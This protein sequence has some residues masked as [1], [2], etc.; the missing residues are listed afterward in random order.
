MQRAGRL[1]LCKKCLTPLKK[2]LQ[3]QCVSS[4]LMGRG[5]VVKYVDTHYKIRYNSLKNSSSDVIARLQD[6]LFSVPA[7]NCTFCS[8]VFTLI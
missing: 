2:P 8:G 5:G 6:L 7:L 1:T 3:N 4:L